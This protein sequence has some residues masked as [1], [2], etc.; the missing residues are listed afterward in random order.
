MRRRVLWINIGLGVLLLAIV[1]AGLA[2]LAPRPA[3]QTGRTIEAQRGTVSETVTATGTVET[4]GGVELAFTTSGV[5]DQ[6]DVAEG[7]TVAAD[8]RIAVLDD[9]AQLQAL[10][11]ARSAYVQ[12]V[13]NASTAPLTLAAAQ[14]NLTAAERNQRLNRQTYAESVSAAREVLADAQSSW[15]ESCLTPEGSCP[16]DTVWAQLRSAEAAIVS[17]QTSY[18][19]AV[20]NATTTAATNQVKLSQAQVNVDAARS[21]Q[22]TQCD[23]FGST[24]A[25]CTS[26]VDALRSAEQA[27]ALQVRANAAS[28][29]AGQQSLVT[30][31]AAVTEANVA[32]RRLQSSLRSAASDAVRAAQNSLDSALLS[33]RKGLE[34]DRQ[35]VQSAREA[36]DQQAAA[37]QSVDIGAESLAPTQ[38]A[39]EVA[40]AGVVAAEAA[41]ADTVLTAPING[42]I[43]AID[44][45]VGD[46]VAAGTSVVT[47]LPDAPFQIVAEFSEAD[48]LKLAT[49]QPAVVSFDA[50]PGTTAT[51]TVSSIATLPTES[52][53]SA[54]SVTSGGVTTYSATITLDDSPA[55]AREGMSVSVVVT[56]QQV[57]DVVW[58]PTAAITTEGGRSTVTIRNGEVDTVVEVTT[59]LA[60]DSGTEITSG[61]QEGDL[62]VIEVGE[63]ST[64]PG[65]GGGDGDG[66]GGRPRDGND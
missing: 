27:Y 47:V 61:V 42:R 35:A 30:A 19:Q 2:M 57:D 16:D 17:A 34:L 9:A 65:F 64:F 54:A 59:G 52:V 36:V 51:G 11:S 32:L 25:A 23:T 46:P 15:S 48:A 10:A 62:L 18:D 13:A 45:T 21:R 56:T 28:D 29:V 40:Q 60:G 63:A 24:S 44:L 55:G 1:G 22:T 20:Q 3:E 39:V 26:A 38:A 43:A 50:L 58:A 49:G 4:A 37:Q 12:A 14:R 6:V 31:D 41:L 53:G 33:Q 8:E 5:V 7:D 66:F